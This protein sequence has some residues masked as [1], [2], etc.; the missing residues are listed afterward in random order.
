MPGDEAEE[1]GKSL[2]C[3]GAHRLAHQTPACWQLGGHRAAQGANACTDVQRVLW[4]RVWPRALT[5]KGVPSGLFPESWHQ[6]FLLK[7][8]A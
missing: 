7:F 2:P 4:D 3:F 8:K 6:D 1:E 5:S